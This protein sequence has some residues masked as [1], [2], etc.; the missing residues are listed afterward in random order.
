[1]DGDLVLWTPRKELR[2]ALGQ[3]LK[4]DAERR[5]DEEYRRLLYVAL[6]RAE[7]RLY[8]CG[9]CDRDEAPRDGCWHRFVSDAMAGVGGVEPFDFG[10]AYDFWP[11][12]GLRL[13]G[14][15]SAP[16]R[17]DGREAAAGVD[18]TALPGWARAQAPPA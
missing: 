3:E 12:E 5:R 14:E 16:A 8:V 15:Q 4:A 18:G 7:D 10:E 11:G 9:W 6:T 2:E 17:P 13:S 1:P